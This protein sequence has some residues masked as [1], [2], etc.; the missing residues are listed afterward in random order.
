M[1]KRT[2]GRVN[3]VFSEDGRAPL[4]CSVGVPSRMIA[5]SLESLTIP[6]GSSLAALDASTKTFE[7]N[8][9]DFASP[10][11]GEAIAERGKDMLLD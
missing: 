9:V 7:P 2:K 3:G 5:S 8:L 11:T 10:S 6:Y 1:G 4:E